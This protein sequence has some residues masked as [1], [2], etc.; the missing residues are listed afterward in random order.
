MKKNS[1]ACG[2]FFAIS[3][4]FHLSVK[5]Q[6]TAIDPSIYTTEGMPK[7]VVSSEMISVPDTKAE[8]FPEN[9]WNFT[10]TYNT[11]DKTLT[12]I[13]KMWIDMNNDGKFE[14]DVDIPIL[15]DP[16]KVN[17]Q[18]PT[19][20]MIIKKSPVRANG[21]TITIYGPIGQLEFLDCKIKSIETK[22]NPYLTRLDASHNRLEAIDLQFNFNLMFL[23]LTANNL[24]E[25]LLCP[26]APLLDVYL[27][28][29]KM[30]TEAMKE[31]VETLPDL[32]RTS[33][34]GG[35]W[36][37]YIGTYDDRDAYGNS[38]TR[39]EE[40]KLPYPIF[41]KLYEKN[42]EPKAWYEITKQATFDKEGKL[43]APDGTVIPVEL[44][45][46]RIEANGEM[47]IYTAER[48]NSLVVNIP[49]ALVGRDYVIYDLAG[50]VC[51]KGFL[52]EQSSVI[53]FA[54]YPV[55]E[56]I[57]AIGDKAYTFIK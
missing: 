22:G 38:Y 24:S 12:G 48:G 16:T 29:N 42:W 53:S 46:K 10:L 32:S 20:A 49:D 9:C 56:Y 34:R 27:D 14:T 7:I 11:N 23:N 50:N 45:A 6:E 39:T 37:C 8:N 28:L 21:S 5:A 30:D 35:I 43:R 26:Q 33:N 15:F 1:L 19:K 13:E 36:L 51:K 44:G 52:D 54:H 18:K 47:V 17:P 55:G 25:I 31:M 3:T 4:L 2:L 57:F 40:N 41:A